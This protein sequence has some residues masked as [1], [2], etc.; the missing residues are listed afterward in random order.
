M[1]G[2]SAI[3]GIAI[4]YLLIISPAVNFWDAVGTSLCR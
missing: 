4:N 2:M 3:E 1:L